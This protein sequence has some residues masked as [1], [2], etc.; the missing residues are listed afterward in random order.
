MARTK[1]VN[2]AVIPL[3]AEEEAARDADEA[4]RAIDKVAEKGRGIR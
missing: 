4:E 3:T 2:G 1:M